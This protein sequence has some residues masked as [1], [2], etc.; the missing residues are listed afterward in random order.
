MEGLIDKTFTP[1]AVISAMCGETPSVLV[2]RGVNRYVGDSV[3][4]F[5]PD[6]SPRMRLYGTVS[7]G[8]LGW[9]TDLAVDYVDSQNQLDVAG[10]KKKRSETACLFESPSR[11]LVTVKNSDGSGFGYVFKRHGLV[12]WKLSELRLIKQPQ[13]ISLALGR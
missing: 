10:E 12:V 13:N 6:G 11:L 8:L 5:T 4:T 7:K 2:K 9:A 3:D 1:E